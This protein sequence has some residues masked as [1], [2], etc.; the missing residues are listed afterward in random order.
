MHLFVHDERE[1]RQ[2][3]GEQAQLQVAALHPLFQLVEA[4]PASHPLRHVEGEGQARHP[5]SAQQLVEQGLRRKE[6]CQAKQPQ[7]VEHGVQHVSVY[8]RAVRHRLYWAPALKR[9]HH[10]DQCQQLQKPH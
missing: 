3:F 2:A 4:L 7:P 8:G 9:P 6:Q 5:H 10:G 1:L